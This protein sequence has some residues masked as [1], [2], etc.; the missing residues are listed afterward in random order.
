MKG[1]TRAISQRVEVLELVEVD[2]DVLVADTLDVA[3]ALPVAVLVAVVV[4]VALGLP[5]EVVDEVD[6]AVEVGDD[7]EVPEEDELPCSAGKAQGDR[8]GRGEKCEHKGMVRAGARA[9]L[10]WRLSLHTPERTVDV[11]DAVEVAEDVEDEVEVF[12]PLGDLVALGLL[13]EVD[14]AVEEPVELDEPVDVLVVL[15]DFVALVEPELVA[16]ALEDLVAVPER[17][18][19]AHERGA[20]VVERSKER[21]RANYAC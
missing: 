15:E 10:L 17:C 1:A 4:T 5:V 21:A 20:P 6:V 16:V 12:E 2:E 7:V 8:V 13:D 9:N 14:D 11:F 18:E 19:G 3:L